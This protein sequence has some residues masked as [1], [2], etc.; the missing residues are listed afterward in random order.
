MGVI[1]GRSLSDLRMHVG[2]DGLFYVGNHGLE[3][4]GPGLLL[5]SCQAAKAQ[6]ELKRLI[7]SLV[8]E[9]ATLDGIFIEEKGVSASVHWRLASEE[10]RK[11]AYAIVRTAVA[12]YPRLQLSS[13][14][15]VWELRPKEGWKKGDA[16]KYLMARLRLAPEDVIYMG[17]D[18]TDEDAFRALPT[19]LTFHVGGKNPE[20][21]ARYRIHDFTDV[22]A[23]LLCLL[24]LRSRMRAEESEIT[25]REA[26]RM[27]TRE[28]V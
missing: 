8:A 26:E 23:L 27:A 14:K 25:A 22:Q 4:C 16:I 3:S 17:D 1:S 11:H 9:T 15:C 5:H 19:G 10:V 2:I 7:D 21:A 13:G 18:L 28:S 12:Q 24:G 20:T 6:R